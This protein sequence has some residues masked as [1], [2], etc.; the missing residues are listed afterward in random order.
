MSVYAFSDIHGQRELFDQVMAEIGPDDTIYFLG[1]A[2]DRGPDGWAILKELMNDPRVIYIKGNHEDMMC[3]AL[4][5][6]PDYPP[7]SNAMSIWNRNGN[8]PTL[9]AIDAEENI[10]ATTNLI[11]QVRALP[12]YAIYTNPFGDIFWLSH[13]GCDYDEEGIEYVP[14]HDLIWDRNHYINNKWYSNNPNNLYIVHGHTPIECLVNDLY[15]YYD[16]IDLDIPE[17]AYYYADGHKIDIDCGTHFTGT[18][19]LLNLDTFEEKVF[20]MTDRENT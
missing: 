19:V 16:D 6:Y 11:S 5:R 12:A 1:D 17:G 20:T 7:I 9:T 10:E 15:S 4:W 18:T 3:N 8:I 14:Y 2:I 13:A